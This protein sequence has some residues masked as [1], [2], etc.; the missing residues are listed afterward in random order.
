MQICVDNLNIMTTARQLAELFR[1]FGNVISSKIV[2]AES[3]G[4]FCGMGFIE[5]DY[6]C[7]RQ[8]IRSLHRLLFMNSYIEV[9]ED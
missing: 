2:R 7:G 9:G 4:R 5:M 1:P 6:L 8:A 3:N